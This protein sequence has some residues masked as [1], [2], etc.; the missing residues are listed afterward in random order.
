MT[1]H[2]SKKA[3]E[4]IQNHDKSNPMFMMLTHLAPHTAN[5]F[6]PMQAPQDEID[7]FDYIQNEKRRIY[8][9]M[10]SK[11]DEGVG[12]VVKALDRN[13]M[14]DNS[15]ILFFSDNGA[16][17]LGEHANSGSNFPFKGQKDSP[18]EG[19]TRTQAAIWSPMLKRRQR[20]SN[21][22]IH[23]SDWLPTFAH[24]AGIHIETPIDGKNIWN[25]IS[26]DLPSP[27]VELLVHHDAE[28]PYM[29]YISKNFK[30][31]SGST[32]NGLYD[33]WLSKPIDQSEE[34]STFAENYSEAILTSNAGQALLKY[35]KSNQKQFDNFIEFNSHV[36]SAKEISEIRLKAKVTCNGHVPPENNSV[37]AC[38][39]IVSPCLFDIFSDPCE[40][41]NL[42][43]EFPN[44]VH[45]LQRKLDHY[46]H[47]AKPIRNKPGD[48]QS[49]PANFGG[50]WTWW[51]DI[52]A[53]SGLNNATTT[54]T[55]KILNTF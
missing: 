54:S 20:V 28:V 44:I 37:A 4:T 45:Q 51:C 13:K 30:L 25:A 2:D 38:N 29:A 17:I 55:G 3:I 39:P 10:V 16:P 31:V 26:F 42:A 46:G 7:K 33:S 50:I 35:S 47:I 41:T 19:A 5:E 18:W 6:D 32:Y 40:T 21:E 15:I 1:V 11:L 12:K 23:I 52:L 27:R 53:E 14:L 49:N 9:A 36:I 34:N 22:M 43:F 24:L 8:A 48:P